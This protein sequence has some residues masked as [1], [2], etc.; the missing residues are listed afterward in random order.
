M[1]EARS[2]WSGASEEEKKERLN[3]DTVDARTYF[4]VEKVEMTSHL[5]GTLGF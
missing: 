2:S 5:K 1:S 4:L 3:L